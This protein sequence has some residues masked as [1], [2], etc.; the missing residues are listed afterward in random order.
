MEKK[1]ISLDRAEELGE[2][3]E[4]KPAKIKG[5]E[6]FM[7]TRGNNHRADP[8]SWDEFKEELEDKRVGIYE[9][10][11]WMQIVREKEKSE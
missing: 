3:K 2:E 1:R 8:L 9:A 11:G 5:S 7:F 10:D 4:L 6:G